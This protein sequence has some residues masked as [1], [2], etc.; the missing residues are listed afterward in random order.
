MNFLTRTDKV[1]MS[2]AILVLVLFSYFLYDDSFLFSHDSGNKLEKIG[3]I[4]QTENDVRL[5]GATSFSWAPAGLRVDVHQK[6]SV[7]TGEGSEVSIQLNDGSVINLQENSLVTLNIKNGEMTLDLKY[8]DF[9]GELAANSQLKVKAGKEEYSLKSEKSENNE[10]A[11]LRINKSRTG[12]IDVKLQ[13]GAAKLQTKTETKKL[14]PSQPVAIAEK[15]KIEE[16]IKPNIVLKTADQTQFTQWTQEDL[17]PLSWDSDTKPAAFTV[18]VAEDENF[19]EILWQKKSTS[20]TAATPTKSGVDTY[21]WRVKGLGPTGQVLAVSPV[22]TFNVTRP[23]GPVILQPKE[24]KPL[25]FELKPNTPVEQQKA[26]FKVTWKADPRLKQFNYQFAKDPEFKE[27]IKEGKAEESETPSPKLS[28]GTYYVRVRGEVRE[29]IFG[30]WSQ[31]RMI[32]LKVTS[33]AIED[34]LRPP[35]LVKRKIEFNSADQARNPS[36]IKAPQI[37]WKAAKGAESYKLEFSKNKQFADPK[38]F[39]VNGE[40]HTWSTFEKGITYFRVYSVSKDKKLSPP[41]QMGLVKVTLNDPQLKPLKDVIINDMAA[42]G[43]PA[44]PQEVVVAWSEVPSAKKYKLEMTSTMKGFKA[45]SFEVSGLSVPVSLPKPGKFKV[46][47]QALDENGKA[48]S[49][50]SGWEDVAYKFNTTLT[51]PSLIEPYDKTTLFMQKDTAPFVWLEWEQVVNAVGY[52]IE[53]SQS[54][55]F[56]KIIFSADTTTPRYLIKQK[57]PYGTIYWRVKA[58]SENPEMHSDWTTNREFSLLFNKNETYQ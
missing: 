49:G 18:E 23:Q 1:L 52:K 37:Q 6:D 15:G 30:E 24:N 28:T 41:S 55:N 26:E 34:K 54:P 42:A 27:I 20:L 22:H 31:P 11:V 40:V 14:D 33:Q 8:G 39:D 21:H 32:D 2:I 43:K 57:I 12:A 45:R 58:L 25:S 7:F 16:I 46:R 5:K 51:A 38:F 48:V 3:L 13:S 56:E 53:I 4:N 50:Y 17:I 47:V 44:P 29:N 19:T 9:V 36:S 35:V 10:K